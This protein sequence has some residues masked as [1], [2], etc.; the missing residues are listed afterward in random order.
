MGV[1]KYYC[2]SMYNINLSKFPNLNYSRLI[3][4]IDDYL[5]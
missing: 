3:T 2:S 4:S 5:F 1:T